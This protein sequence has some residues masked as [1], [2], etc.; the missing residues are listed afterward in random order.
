MFCIARVSADRRTNLSN[1]PNPT[2][3]LLI[4]SPCRVFYA[5]RVPLPDAGEG[6]EAVGAAEE[7]REL[8]Q[9]ELG[10]GTAAT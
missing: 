2:Y 3:T 6:M 1:T 5:P 8:F 9:L 7:K 10:E 4:S